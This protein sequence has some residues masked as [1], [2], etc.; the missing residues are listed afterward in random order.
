V[1]TYPEP[2]SIWVYHPIQYV[3]GDS[4]G[5]CPYCGFKLAVEIKH[6]N[7]KPIPDQ[8]EVFVSIFVRPDHV[9]HQPPISAF[10]VRCVPYDSRKIP[11]KVPQFLQEIDL[12][13]PCSTG[14]HQ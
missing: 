5:E 10:I 8:C 1:N 12:K 6:A 2:D 13:K 9:T 7:D 4:H 14:V 3:T 11:L